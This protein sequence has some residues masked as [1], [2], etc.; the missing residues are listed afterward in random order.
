[1]LSTLSLTATV[2][3]DEVELND[4]DLLE[5]IG[6][7][8]T[9]YMGDRSITAEDFAVLEARSVDDAIAD[10]SLEA[11]DYLYLLRGKWAEKK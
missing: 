9:A 6:D 1:M 8:A 5:S 10:Y 4:L 2:A 3:F 11:V 7:Q